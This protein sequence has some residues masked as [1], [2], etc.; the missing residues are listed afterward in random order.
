MKKRIC[1]AGM[2]GY[3]G[4]IL[5]KLINNHPNFELVGSLGLSSNKK[6]QY[7]Y[8]LDDLNSE[9]FDVDFLLLATPADISIEIVDKINQKNINTKILD[10]SGA[11][12][13][14]KEGLERWYGLTHS[15]PA[16]D[17][18][19]KYGLSP[20]VKFSDK[21]TLIANPGCYATCIL[22]SIIPLLKNNLIKPDNI[23]IDA[24]SGVSGAG[25]T[26]SSELM[27]SEML[28]NFYPYKIGKHQHTPEILKYL[29]DFNLEEDN[30]FLSTSMLPIH[31]GISISIYADLNF[32]KDML[33]NNDIKRVI[34]EAYDNEYN[35]YPLFKFIDMTKQ[36]NETLLS[37]LSIKSVVNTPNTQLGFLVKGNKIIIFACIDNLLKGAAT[38]ALENLNNYYDLPVDTGL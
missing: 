23:I 5:K 2:N 36:S 17:D 25:K 11:F 7:R 26:P 9:N 6:D 19:A 37:F 1:I 8:F 28:N 18:G 20:Y 35:N 14:K 12:R 30:F 27:F 24:K 16:F 22:L 21:D 33:N 10:L 32:S 31:S 34:N 38:Q 15:I 29:A 13:L 4:Q 3:T